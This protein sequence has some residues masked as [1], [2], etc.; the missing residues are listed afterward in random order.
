MAA[1][2]LLWTGNRM[3]RRLVYCSVEFE[4]G[5]RMTMPPRVTDEIV[6][7]APPGVPRDAPG[8]PLSRLLPVAMIVATIGMMAFYFTSGASAMR[9]PM[10]MF[11]PVMMLVSLVGTVASGSHGGTRIADINR[12]RRDYLRYLTLLDSQIVKMAEQQRRSTSWAHPEPG[13]LWTFV[14]GRRMWERGPDETDFAHVRVG[15]GVQPLSTPL[16]APQLPPPEDLDP[17]TSIEMRRL[18]RDRSTVPDLPVSI[19]L[20]EIAAITVDGDMLAVRSLLRAVV[21]QLAV[22]HSPRDLRIAVAVDPI[23]AR[24]WDWLKWLPHH[25]HPDGVDGGG[26]ARLTYGSLSSAAAALSSWRGAHTVLLVDGG[27]ITGTEGPLSRRSADGMTVIE[28]GTGSDAV[29]GLNLVLSGDDLFAQT[30]DDAFARPD[31]MTPGQALACARRMS[32]FRPAA[33]TIGGPA[34]IAPSVVWSELMGVTDVG[35]FDPVARWRSS[36]RPRNAL[37]VPIGVS[38]LGEAVELDIKEAAA[39]GMGPHGLC[40]GATGSGKS[41]FLRTLTLGMIT[42][43]PPEVL[44]LVL[45]D[46]KGGA[47]FLGLERAP[48]VSAVITNL[49][50]EAH[51]VARMKDALAGEMTRRQELLR[52]TG[53]FANVADYDRARRRSSGSTPLPALFIVVDEFSELLSQQPDFIDL[54]IAVGRLG[55]SLG[56]HLLLASQRVDEGR[57]RGLES[58]LSYRVCLK[59]FSASESRS[60]L[61]VADAYTL[62]GTPGAAYLKTG[63][64]DPVRFQTAFVSAPYV[65]RPSPSAELAATSTPRLFTAAPMGRITFGTDQRNAHPPASVRTIIDTVVDRLEGSGPPA[66]QVWLPPLATAPNLDVLLR[67][68]GARVG[69]AVPIGLVDRPF[70]QRRDLLVAQLDGAGGNVAVV[71]GPRAGKST[72]LRT[73]VQALAE[74][75]D[76]RD[77]HVYCLDFGGG[78]LSSLL[79]LPHVGSV[80]TRR[81]VDLIRRTVAHLESLLRE[82]ESQRNSGAPDAPGDTYSEVFLV[83]DGWATIRQEFDTVEASITAIASQGLS[84]GIHLVVSASRWAE[85]RPALKDQIGTRIEL[86][87]GDPAESEMDRKRARHLT[88][89]PPGRGITRDGHEFVIALPGFDAATAGRLRTRYA[90]RTAPPI[91]VLPVRVDYEAVV[92]RSHEPRPATHVMVGV[93]ESELE[94][95]AVD[96]AAESHLIVLGQGECGKTTTLRTLC[97]EIVRTNVSDSAQLFIVDPRR[98]LLG[99]VESD[100]LAGYAPSV[101][102]LTPQLAA[103]IVRLQRRMPGADVSQQQ[104]RTRSW[105]SGPEIYV[106]IDDYDL[107]V[108]AAGANPLAPLVDL[109]PH[110]KDVGL[111]VVVARRSGGAARAMFDPVLARLRE[112][113]CMGLMMSASPDE[114]VLLGSVRPSQLPPG[115]ATLVTRARSEQFIQ[116]AWSDPA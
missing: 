114:G 43:H 5:S 101:S 12:D 78:A 60:V 54:F 79:E 109:L 32:R 20:K 52:A 110:A 40:I 90:G 94:P 69:L 22:M 75:H 96:F 24:D 63:A 68:S 58:H 13:A 81:D 67:H 36:S 27:L 77:V 34:H 35:D 108:P 103:L 84:Y 59:T 72:A 113:G 93:S 17:V 88:K 38:E 97:R 86:R 57:L 3:G 44:N 48:H 50:D 26:S 1:G 47:T 95:A 14:G 61:G 107:I 71:G 112:L 55:R 99:V 10:F 102:A 53:N 19:A 115:R 28:L 42:A 16:V 82:R 66:H 74:S 56:M 25:Q 87:L 85:I 18:I 30:G 23:T 31:M 91:Q 62:P 92:A 111:H 49:A 80:A 6:I 7:Q 46:F 37:C 104:L 8:N 98:T 45:V 41:E 4:I 21:C 9:N 29:A 39:N 15:L 70:E 105:W 51:L 2:D 116:I 83:I 33:T 65:G 64:A 100:H 106:V 73:L 76:P 89:S 11:F